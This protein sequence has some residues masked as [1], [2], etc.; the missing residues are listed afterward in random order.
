MSQVALASSQSMSNIR[1]DQ[2]RG[3]GSPGDTLQPS[4][5]M[6]SVLVLNVTYEPLNVVPLRRAI[7]LLL[8][9]KAEIVEATNQRLRSAQFSMPVPTV[10]RLVCFIHVPRPMGISLTRKSVMMRDNYTCQYCG[11]QPTKGELTIDHVIPRVQGG[12]TTWENV[13]CA[14]KRCNLRKG[15]RTPEQANMHLL[16]QPQKPRYLAVMWLSWASEQ[17]PWDKYLEPWGVA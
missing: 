17:H 7:V 15:A 3:M 14:C 11:S 8:K 1:S 9:E 5:A 13:V 10:I 6:S 2:A 12:E 16:Q 4:I